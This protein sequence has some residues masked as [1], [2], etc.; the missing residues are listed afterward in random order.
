MSGAKFLL[1]IHVGQHPHTI[2]I[3]DHNHISRNRLTIYK[4]GT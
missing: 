4:S 1:A 3:S 2:R